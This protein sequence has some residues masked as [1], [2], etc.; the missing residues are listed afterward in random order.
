MIVLIIPCSGLAGGS[1]ITQL[2]TDD[3]GLCYFKVHIITDVA[4]AITEVYL[5]PSRY[6]GE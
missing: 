1:S 4:P 6:V 2:V 3:I 5:H